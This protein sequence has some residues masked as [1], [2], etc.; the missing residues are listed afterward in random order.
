MKRTVALVSIACALFATPAIAHDTWILCD[1]PL[2]AAGRSLA[3]H[4]TS[5]ESFPVMGAAPETSRIDRAEWRIGDRRGT[6]TTFETGKSSLVAKDRVTT[7]GVAV[8]F[9]EF[10]PQDID[11]EPAE[12]AEYLDEIG[13]P[14]SV[15][16]AYEKEGPDATFHETFTKHAKTYVR[17]GTGGDASGC[18]G[19]VGFAIDFLPDRDPTSLK[20]GDTLA[21][22]AIR[23]GRELES[24]AVG[25]VCAA[26][27]HAT[28]QRTSKSGMIAISIDKPGWWLVR[29]TEL[30]R[31]ADKTWE[32]DFTTMTF[33]VEK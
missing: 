5:G 10:R 25:V 17:I 22:K 11:L 28:M 20:V 24:F 30:R 29:S 14:E 19:P 27:G 18:L 7:D 12:V 6:I 3:V 21:I 13:A 1:P 15:R 16:R 23:G 31:K 33:Y 32:S 9:V 4:V 2:V 26:D 8:V